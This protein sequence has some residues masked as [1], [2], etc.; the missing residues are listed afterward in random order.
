MYVSK[1]GNKI[2]LFGNSTLEAPFDDT[3]FVS[4]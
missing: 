4:G 2:M 3:L 1:R